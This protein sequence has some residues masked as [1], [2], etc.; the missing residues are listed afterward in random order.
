MVEDII[1]IMEDL[2]MEDDG[3]Y[4]VSND[5]IKYLSRGQFIKYSKKVDEK[6]VKKTGFIVSKNENS[7]FLK[8]HSHFWTIR[9]DEYDIFCQ[10]TFQVRHCCMNLE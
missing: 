7:L 2:P 4:L 6:K 10:P 8:N 9:L 1:T 5:E 3:Y